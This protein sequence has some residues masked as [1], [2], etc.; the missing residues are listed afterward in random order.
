LN[1]GRADDFTVRPPFFLCIGIAYSR[2][3]VKGINSNY[4]IR[5]KAFSWLE[6]VLVQWLRVN[7]DYM[8]E[9]DWGDCLY[10]YNERANVSALAAAM[11]RCG[12]FAVEEYSSSKGYGETAQKN[13]RVDLYLLSNGN[14]AI[15]EAKMDWIY[16]CK[17]QRLNLDDAIDKA[18]KRATESAEHT[19][20]AYDEGV[21]GMALNFV[22]AYWKEG[23]D[24]SDSLEALRMSVE[25]SKCSFFAWLEN[26]SGA[27]IVSSNSNV[28]NFIAL[29][30]TVST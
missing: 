3:N 12:G 29:L 23:E 20:K 25:K 8:E 13:G 27:D 5:K 2:G 21:C 9:T 15:C 16:L 19:L 28:F 18:I 6:P 26:D 24:V 22:A 14:E 10:W 1:E 7:R 11:W 4:K 17:N 30:G